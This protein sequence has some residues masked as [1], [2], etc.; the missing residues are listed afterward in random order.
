MMKNVNWKE[1][2]IFNI[3]WIVGVVASWIL[4]KFGNV[5]G[6]YVF[7]LILLIPINL[8]ILKK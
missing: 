2:L 3:V 7:L 5:D 1:L 4:Q 8:Y 6:F